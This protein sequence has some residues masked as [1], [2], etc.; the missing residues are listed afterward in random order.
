M[1]GVRGLTPLRDLLPTP[2]V[3]AARYSS[4]VVAEN[5]TCN[6]GCGGD[7]TVTPDGQADLSSTPVAGAGAVFATSSGF[8]S[9]PIGT[10][11]SLTDYADP[12]LVVQRGSSVQIW[13]QVD[14]SWVAREGD[15]V[16]GTMTVD[17]TTGNYV[18]T[19][20]DGTQWVYAGASPPTGCQEGQLLSMT[21]PGGNGTQYYYDPSSGLLSSTI[22]TTGL[23][24]EQ[25]VDYDYAGSS[26]QVVEMDVFIGLSTSG[27]DTSGTPTRRVVYTYYQTGASGY[28]DGD[29][30]GNPGDLELVT[31]YEG[32]SIIDQTYYS[33]YQATAANGYAHLLECMFTG[34][35]LARAGLYPIDPGD[36]TVPSTAPTV[37]LTQPQITTYADEY[38][39]YNA[40]GQVV[41]RST[42]GTGCSCAGGQGT[43][44]YAYATNASFSPTD[45][46]LYNQW[47]YEQTDTLGD[48]TVVTTFYNYRQ[49][50]L[51]VDT[52]NS[53]DT[54]D[55][56]T[57]NRYD[58]DGNLVLTAEPSAFTA[59]NG[60]YYDTGYRD[61]IDWSSG[62]SPYLSNTSGLFQL[63]TYY[64]GNETLPTTAI[65][66]GV[67]GW[68]YQ[69]A[70][71]DGETAARLAIG[72]SGGPIL[73]ST[74]DYI[75]SPTVNGVKAYYTAHSIQYGDTGGGDPRTT[76]YS[77]S[78][79]TSGVNGPAIYTETT[80][81]PVVSTGQHGPGG[82]TANTT[83]DVYDT[84]G[85]VV[86]SMDAAGS[87]SYTQYDPATGAVVEQ[88]QDVDL[89]ITSDI[90]SADLELLEGSPLPST[91][92]GQG[93]GPFLNLVTTYLVDSLGRTVEETD[94]VGNETAVVYDDVDHEMRIYPGWHESS[95]DWQPTGPVEV[96]REDWTGNYTESATYSWDDPGAL[97]TYVSGGRP[98]GGESLTNSSV[99]I[100][101]LSRDLEN[102]GGQVTHSLQYFSMDGVTYSPTTA[103]P[104]VEG[105]N[106][107]QTDYYYDL[108][109]RLYSRHDA[110]GSVQH[111][112][113]D[114]LGRVTQQW[115]GTN[116]VPIDTQ[117][118][119]E[120]I[121]AYYP[122]PTGDPH[123]AP[124]PRDFHWWHL[125]VD[126]TATVSEGVTEAGQL[127]DDLTRMYL[128]SANSY[129]ADGNL[130]ES[131]SYYDPS[132]T[133]APRVT[134]YQY[135]WR[136]REVGTLTPDGA[137]TIYSA[138][139]LGEV[140][141]TQIYAGASYNT[142]SNTIT[143]TSSGLRA[144]S[145]TL[146][147]DQGRVYESDQFP[148]DQST[149]D[150]SA[151]VVNGTWYDAV[152]NVVQTTDALGNVTTYEY[153]SLGRQ[154]K[155]IEPDPDTGLSTTNSPTISTAY[156]ADGNVLTQT[157]ALLNVTSYVYD[158]VGRKTEEDRT[159]PAGSGAPTVTYYAYDSAGNLASVTDP[160]GRITSY[161]YD[162]AGRCTAVILPELVPNE[163]SSSPEYLYTYDADGRVLTQTDPLLN[164]TSYQY[165][166]L[167]DKVRETDPA[168][169][170]GNTTAPVT[171]WTYDLAGE[172]TSMT[173][174]LG[175]TTQYQYDNMGRL[176]TVTQP[177]PTGATLA[178]S[179]TYS[180]DAFGNV[181]S[182]ADALGHG[183]T[184]TYDGLGR[185][186]TVTDANSATT[187]YT[188]DAVGNMLTETEP[189]DNTTTWTYDA[190][191]RMTGETNQLDA[192]R[193]YFYDAAGELVQTADRDG[194]AIVYAYDHLG[195]RPAKR[196]TRRP[197]PITGRRAAPPR[198][199][200]TRTTWM[201]RCSRRPTRQPPT[202]ILT[203]TSGASRRSWPASRDWTP[204]LPSCR[205]STSTA[206]AR[207]L[208]RQ[209]TAPRTSPTVSPTTTLAAQRASYSRA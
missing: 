153:D 134:H 83:T 122:R 105:T 142:A 209:S 22:T 126:T 130:I 73:Q 146:Y 168:P 17:Q 159:N 179:T 27:P 46:D 39:T 148:V 174:P 163:P 115:V 4:N 182:E 160:L 194:R 184:Y 204:R 74:I 139:N 114:Y 145:E 112:F 91:G 131:D 102:E 132:G 48:G 169:G 110:D 7:L 63:S 119:D 92:E 81:L 187:S 154:T 120:Y 21:P 165:D 162:M 64:P 188:F 29:S 67:P 207:S 28:Q 38:L 33:Y 43:T 96:S 25:V 123:P 116:D 10:A 70:V 44:T 8:G 72:S 45:S 12:S 177:L 147:D 49:Q 3:G 19:D 71:A 104:G 6:C 195:A 143:T 157:D 118:D 23:S 170:N 108:R 144:Q 176:A 133:A 54:Q 52:A 171:T 80:S 109:G 50:P 59:Y 40:A 106:Y 53:A 149:G 18:E 198:R 138:D 77:Y 180:Y 15:T 190:L 128:V 173:D 155:V 24:T 186:A 99:T 34:P 127:D 158:A 196:G 75:A 30:C 189:D 31:T 51:L 94:P 32:S 167:G 26:D 107:L 11:A 90:A 129:D 113:Y 41:S 37:A 76:T 20:P 197:T 193:Y 61:L 103:A 65:A 164:V 16:Q 89:S 85:R 5:N 58:A 60:D 205:S 68:L 175:N 172:M 101:S 78:F 82:T 93:E 191:N 185:R 136:D 56:V 151:P 117:E 1:A 9:Q 141:G 208:R 55:S 137:A 135:D 183:T 97:Q 98:T 87:I 88:I 86:W 124:D 121:Y 62:D 57:Y 156:D 95:G 2:R 178:P 202:A 14:G 111:T 201:A 36:P 125:M 181:L 206:C 100:Q 192:T 161:Q 140:T 79:Y 200:A 152:G 199:S 47:L 35:S 69:T 203:T 84:Y 66:S 150:T 166:F 13:D 42:G